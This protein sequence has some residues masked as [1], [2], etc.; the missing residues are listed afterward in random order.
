MIRAGIIGCGNISDIYLKNLSRASNVKVT[1]VSDQIPERAQAKAAQYQ[2]RSLAVDQLLADDAIDMV[3]N[4]TVPAAHA[5][6]SQAALEAGKHVY[7][8]KPLA[9]TSAEGRRLLEVSQA[10]GRRIGSAPDT[11]LG[12]GI[13]TAR[14][15]IDDGWIGEPVAASAFMTCHGHEHW[16][17]DPEF[18]YQPGGGPLFDMGPYYLSALFQLMGPVRRVTSIAAETFAERVIGSE[19]HR[20]E[21]ITVRTPTHVAGSLEF[22]GGAV[23]TLITSFDVWH[24]RLPRIEIYGSEATLAVPDPN[25]FGGPVEIRRFDAQEWSPVPLLSGQSHNAR[26]LGALDL[27]DAIGE[28]RMARADG[29]IAY[30]VLEVMEALLVSSSEG[31]HREIVS[32]PQRPSPMPW[33]SHA[34]P[35]R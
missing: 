27:A 23:A 34:L 10:R 14:K 19:P 22:H 17:P 8:E 18:F 21:R 3:I 26:G 1:A 4:L 9:L 32:R 30:H 13:Q 2:I 28:G 29:V 11:V 7:G 6:I 15:M 35:G 24:A 25:T 33:Q 20:G 5:A 12:P 16:H 31:R